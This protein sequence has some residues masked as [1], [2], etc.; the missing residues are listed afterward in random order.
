MHDALER[1]GGSARQIGR[2]PRRAAGRA[3][4]FRAVQLAPP[5]AVLVDDVIT[6]GATLAA[7]AQALRAAGAHEVVAVSY[8]RTPG[9]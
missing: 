5:R 6:T 9:R 2:E 7:C 3:P 1:R 8:A 4:R